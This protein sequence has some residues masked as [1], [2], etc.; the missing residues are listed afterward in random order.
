MKYMLPSR[1]EVID[2]TGGNGLG[3]ATGS[4]FGTP[5]VAGDNGEDDGMGI[6]NFKDML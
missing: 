1:N 3:V 6:E 2:A 5:G 4:R